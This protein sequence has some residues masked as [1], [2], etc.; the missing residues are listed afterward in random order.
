MEV[1]SNVPFLVLDGFGNEI[2]NTYIRD[3]IVLPL[4]SNRRRNRCITIITSNY[5][6]EDIVK[7]YSFKSKEIHPSAKMILDLINYMS[8]NTEIEIKT[9]PGLYR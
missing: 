4:L 6:V 5:D 3:A 9:I 8:N 7:L 2:K 1:L